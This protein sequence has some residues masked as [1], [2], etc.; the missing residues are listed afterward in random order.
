MVAHLDEKEIRV[1]KALHRALV[2]KPFNDSAADSN[3]DTAEAYSPPRIS[4]AAARM[5]LKGEVCT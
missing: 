4:D 3:A 1:F 2:P 5:G